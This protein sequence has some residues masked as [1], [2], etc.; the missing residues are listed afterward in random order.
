VLIQSRLLP[1]VLLITYRLLVSKSMARVT[2]P[3]SLYGVVPMCAIAGEIVSLVHS[4]LGTAPL[5]AE[6]MPRHHRCAFSTAASPWTSMSR[7]KP[8]ATEPKGTRCVIAAV[9]TKSSREAPDD[10]VIIHCCRWGCEHLNP[11]TLAIRT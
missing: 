2:G 3:D 9:K 5:R 7:T 10:R 8:P 1:T 6:P 4:F 11:M